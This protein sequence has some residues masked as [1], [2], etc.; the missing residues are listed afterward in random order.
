MLPILLLPIIS[1]LI[2]SA[3]AI[4]ISDQQPLGD[5]LGHSDGDLYSID[6]LPGSSSGRGLTGRFL[7]I[8][9]LH[10]DSHYK[11]GRSVDEDDACHRGK[12]PAGYFG[13][14]GTEC[15]SPLTL[16]NETFRWIEKN[17]KGHIDFVIWT[18]DSARHDNDEKIPRTEEE[19]SALNE[20]IAGKFIETFKEGSSHFPS[21]PIV[22]TLG[23]ND[24]MPH[25]IFN[26]GPNRWTKRFVDV[27]AKFI[28]EHQ[29]HTFVEGG[30]FT[31]EVIPN[32]LTVISLNT[33]YFFDSNSAVD[34]CSA[35]SQ[36]G[37]EHMEWLR[38]QLQLL[39]SR[40]MKAILIGHVPPARSGSKRSWD[41]TCWQKYTLWVHQY[42]DI[43]VGTAYGHMNIDHFMLQDSRKVDILDA[44]SKSSASSA[45]AD[46]TSPLVSVQSR[47]SYLVDLRKDWSKMPSPPPGISDL[48]ELF[49]D[50]P[51]EHTENADLE[52]LM[53]K[54]KR[55]KFLKKIGG[56]WAERYSV[57]LVSPS[58]V[59]N[60]FPSLRVVEYN[61]SGLADATT[62]AEYLDLDTAVASPS[63]EMI[64]D[65][66]FIEEKKKGKK[67]KKKN[68]P[69]FKV[70]KPPSSSAPPGPAYS[71]QP[72]TW[73]GYTQYYANLTKINEHMTSSRE[74]AGG[75]AS[76]TE[77]E[78]NEVSET[79]HGEDAFIYEVEYDTR[80][81]RIYKM[82]D[83]T[84]RSFFEL[85][86]RI[87]KESS[88]KND[89]SADTTNVNGLPASKTGVVDDY[90][91]DDFEQQ[92]KKK[93]KNAQNKVWR[94][95]LERAFVGFLDSDD[96]DDMS[97]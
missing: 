34:G 40:D 51:T 30:W 83:L 68:K 78:S 33:M 67:K 19:V 21:I 64:E 81:D 46:D 17:L 76:P 9:D 6:K 84:V 11:A 72:L 31:S 88:K 18:G 74:V 24:F 63:F 32:K 60:Y 66:A 52:A 79:S 80:D 5:R 47:Q 75:S 20:I 85:A 97:E 62:W 26:D 48:Y 28:P 94:T 1:T 86:T 45:V 15:D 82:E 37:F 57:S 10:P 14:E 69:H 70:P 90:D 29:R 41:E 8:T 92:K 38:V 96:L 54:K 65:D 55:R 39:R 49:E 91:D 22:P 44:S 25:N 77:T 59:P 2:G 95:F 93:K 71:N 35:K 3:S 53:S 61:I 16:I 87:A 73:L 12:G 36:P 13:S 7:H 50:D 4:P 42:R 27:W 23:N 56:P 89:I 43:I 58:V